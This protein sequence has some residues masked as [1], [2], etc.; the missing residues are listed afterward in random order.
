MDAKLLRPWL[1]TRGYR[2][3]LRQQG[4]TECLLC[5]GTE[6]WMGTGAD[7]A[8]A[9]EHA[10]RQAFPSSVSWELLSSALRAAPAATSPA[11]A[12]P[13]APSPPVAAP[14]PAS[15][16]TM[17][18]GVVPLAEGKVL[19]LSHPAAPV[20]RAVAAAPV[21]PEPE[22]PKET[23]AQ[24]MD[25]VDRDRDRYA[26]CAPRIQR[27]VLW[28]WASRMRVL[29]HGMRIEPRAHRKLFDLSQQWWPGSVGALRLEARPADVTR[30]LE[31]DTERFVDTWEEAAELAHAVLKENLAKAKLDPSGWADAARLTPRPE[32]PEVRLEA[33]EK[34]LDELT[35]NDAVPPLEVAVRWV[36]TGRWLR[37]AT[38]DPQRWA[39]LMGRLRKLTK[40]QSKDLTDAARELEAS[41][42]P[43]GSWASILRFEEQ[44]RKEKAALEE[45]LASCPPLEP[46]LDAELLRAWIEKA[47]THAGVEAAHL[48]RVLDKAQELGVELQDET[49][50]NLGRGVR[51]KL[52]R[53]RELQGLRTQETGENAAA[54]GESPSGAVAVPVVE[55]P[56]EPVVR[57]D[58]PVEIVAALK[59]STQGKRALFVSNRTEDELCGALA[60]RLG[61]TRMDS[62]VIDPRRLA[63]AV[64]RIDAGSYAFVFAATGFMRHSA[65][66]NLSAACRR[67]Q[68]RYVRVAKA[69]ELA[70]LRALENVL[71]PNNARTA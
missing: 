69:R 36:R 11:P 2:V 20:H 62:E 45:L 54:S 56:E 28:W 53:T 66:E 55:E 1:E 35:A 48:A 5:H 23:P 7:D 52:R 31:L 21:A 16:S 71:L 24:V 60:E 37:G 47:L 43:S 51:R 63:S 59:E 19:P 64:A 30:D 27:A 12:P 26:L 65:D 58:F 49:F 14:K 18:S 10:V 29:F 67:A 15:S 39:T 22:L 70:V 3:H 40:E 25:E 68:V 34:E 32:D 13:A 9:L 41:Y 57:N 38:R 33:L 42:A 8:E 61:F 50:D 6:R 46:G 44:Q 4:W 17:L